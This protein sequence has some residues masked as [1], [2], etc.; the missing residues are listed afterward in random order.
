[1]VKMCRF[2]PDRRC[3]HLSCGIFSSVS[4]NVEVCSLY[5]GGDMFACRKVAP[6]HVSI[7]SKHVLRRRGGDLFG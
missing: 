4:G 3:Y 7:F 2:Y 6:V 1:M 5:R